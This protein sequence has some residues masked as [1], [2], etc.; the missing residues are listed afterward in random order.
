[1]TSSLPVAGVAWVAPVGEGLGVVEAGL[2]VG[3]G[4][5][6][7]LGF[8]VTVGLGLTVGLGVAGFGLASGFGVVAGDGLVAGEALGEGDWAR[9]GVTDKLSN[10]DTNTVNTL[11]RRFCQ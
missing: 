10:P 8:G 3:L 2:D 1:M 4:L 9:V 11:L 6:V 7:G 5:A